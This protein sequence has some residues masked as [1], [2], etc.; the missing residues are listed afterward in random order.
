MFLDWLQY[1]IRDCFFDSDDLHQML[2]RVLSSLP[3]PIQDLLGYSKTGYTGK[4]SQPYTIGKGLNYYGSCL[5][6]ECGL[7][8]LYN[9]PQEIMGTHII[10][11]GSVLS[12]KP[13][14][15]GDLSDW[16]CKIL[17]A[18]DYKISR[19]DIAQ[20]CDVDFSYFLEKFNRGEYISRYRHN[21]C[22][23]FLDPNNR[24][25]LYF[26]SRG[27]GTFIRI[28]D[29]FAE[30]LDKMTSKIHQKEFLRSNSGKPWTR[31]EMECRGPQAEQMLNCFILEQCG[32]VFLG[33]LRIVESLQEK[34]S[35]C[36]TDTV[37]LSIIKA[38]VGRRLMCKR[39]T[40]FNVDW[41]TRVAFR[42]VLAIREVNPQLFNMLLEVL[43]PSVNAVVKAQNAR[44][45]LERTYFSLNRVINGADGG[46][47]DLIPDEILKELLLPEL[48]ES[49]VV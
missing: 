22:K 37:Y 33:H 16:F 26:G 47:P 6:F 18:Y 25:T 43:Q 34:K 3:F 9:P 23:S 21:S 48:L 11:P 19:C 41:N 20:D 5:T 4:S 15:P 32:D 12:D 1:T 17:P 13:L 38:K 42:N 30:Q 44:Q 46:S 10:I 49:Q 27:G 28:Y 35:R 29:K 8:V 24:G 2:G 39:S 7:K 31:I 40:S 45:E 14:E 36:K